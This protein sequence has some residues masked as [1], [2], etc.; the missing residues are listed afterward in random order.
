MKLTKRQI[1]KLKTA[2]K[3]AEKAESMFASATGN[4]ASVIIDITGV[5]GHVGHLAGDGFGFT[6]ESNNDTHIGIDKLIELAE[7]GIEITEAEIID[8]LT[9]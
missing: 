4:L 9:F 7:Q 5:N 6:P 1:Q 8:H 2:F 3:N